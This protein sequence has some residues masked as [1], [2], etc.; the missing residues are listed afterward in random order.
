MLD[1]RNKKV[2]RVKVVPLDVVD[3]HSSKRESKTDFFAGLKNDLKKL[4][5]RLPNSPD[6]R[7]RYETFLLKNIV[8]KKINF[9]IF[10]IFFR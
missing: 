3:H 1:D 7:I 9:W 4:V 5:T 2:V 10:L 8:T 6:C